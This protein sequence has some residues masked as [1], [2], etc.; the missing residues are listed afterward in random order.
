MKY[1]NAK[2]VLPEELLSRVQEYIQG[3]YLYVPVREKRA[4]ELSDAYKT[5]LGKRDAHIYTGY[6]EG[7][8][9]KQ[10]SGIYNLSESSVRR[11]LVKQRKGN[12]HMKDKIADVI[13]NWLPKDSAIKQIHDTAW[14][15]GDGYVLKVYENLDMLERNLKILHILDG[16]GIPVGKVIPAKDGKQYVS[17]GGLFYFLSEKLPGSNI[18]RI[19][20]DEKPGIIMGEVIADLHMAFQRCEAAETFWNNSLSDEMEG[21]VKAVFE[22]NGWT[23]I[24]EEEYGRL[25]TDLSAVY[26]KLP[27]QLIHRDVHFGN[28]LFADGRFSGYIDFDLSQRNIRIFD[29]CYFLLGALSEKEK[30]ELTDELWFA[31]AKNVFTGYERKLRLT[32]TE[33]R[34]VPC[35]MKCIELLFAAYYESVDDVRRAK[36]AMSLFAFVKKQEDRIWR[37]VRGD[38]REI[39]KTVQENGS[40]AGLSKTDVIK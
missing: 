5:E 18:V 26:D 32:E 3:E 1:K 24:G 19:G 40:F 9:R 29:L 4:A 15:I 7:M 39:T 33:K 35:V 6:L 27:V 23:Y 28:F 2:D 30:F 36:N 12:I 20:S 31:F 34:L 8:S 17:C 21:W 11:I 13:H 25:V 38:V 10:L 14:Q 22:A 37:A 16:M